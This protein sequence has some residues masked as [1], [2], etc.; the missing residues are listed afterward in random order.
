MKTDSLQIA[1]LETTTAVG[2]TVAIL[3]HRFNNIVQG[4]QGGTYLVDIGFE[5]NDISIAKQ[6]WEI[7][8]RNQE[9]LAE[10]LESLIDLGQ[11]IKL[12][13][14][15]Q[16][17]DQIGSLIEKSLVETSEIQFVFESWFSKE[18][19]DR[20]AN[21]DVEGIA[22]IVS[23]LAGLAF[24]ASEMQQPKINVV[25][26]EIEPDKFFID[27]E[28]VGAVICTTSSEL[29]RCLH[30]PISSQVGGVEFALSEKIAK[31]H[32]GSVKVHSASDDDPNRKIR[33]EIPL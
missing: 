8:K 3:A 11:H 10:L 28:Y 24:L 23:K 29:K 26:G 20:T 27:F 18:P 31:A 16:T 25:A 14:E 9:R 22:V 13:L 30:I 12:D 1:T 5:R 4:T 15:S 33:V 17:F 32:G 6:G 2:Q 7:V 21:I 19:C